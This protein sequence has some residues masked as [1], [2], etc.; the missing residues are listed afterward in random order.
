MGFYGRVIKEPGLTQFTFDRIYSS[1]AE[2]RANEKTDGIY[3]GRFVLVEYTNDIALTGTIENLNEYICIKKDNDILYSKSTIVENDI[4]RVDDDS[5]VKIYQC[6]GYIE[7][8]IAIFK[9]IYSA[10]NEEEKD[11]YNLNFNI[12][13]GVFGTIGRGYDSTVWQKVFLDD[14]IVNEKYVM[15]AELNSVVPEFKLTPDAPTM[16]PIPPHFDKESTDTTYWLHS[17]PN[18]GF[19]VKAADGVSDET[20]DRVTAAYNEETGD[21]TYSTE[22][23]NAAIYYNKAGFDSEKQVYDTLTQNNVNITTAK[24]GNKYNTHGFGQSMEEADDIQEISVIL[25]S[26]GNT[27]SKM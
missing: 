13:K 24:S 10:H 12:D 4:V 15:V 25:P 16:N 20:I 11:I 19:R 18:W 17:Q 9:L 3:S 22:K 2:A 7:N 21:I 23:I 27:V 5:V 1:L 6:N 26:L 14:D 8:D